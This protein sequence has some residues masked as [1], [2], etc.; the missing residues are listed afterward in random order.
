MS[1]VTPVGNNKVYLY[2]LVP[3]SVKPAIVTGLTVP[4]VLSA[5]LPKGVPLSVTVSPEKIVPLIDAEP[6]RVTLSSPS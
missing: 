1:A 6:K 5:K 3:L 2:A 4:T